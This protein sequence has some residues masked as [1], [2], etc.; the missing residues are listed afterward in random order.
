ML[1]TAWRRRG[2]SGEDAKAGVVWLVTNRTA[3]HN[4]KQR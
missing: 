4:M 3:I 2:S 1:G